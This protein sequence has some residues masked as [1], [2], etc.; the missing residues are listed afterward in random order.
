MSP[1]VFTA[2]SSFSKAICDDQGQFGERSKQKRSLSG[3]SGL[4]RFPHLEAAPGCPWLSWKGEQAA[5][6]PVPGEAA[7]AALWGWTYY[8]RAKE[9]QRE[10]SQPGQPT[11]QGLC[12]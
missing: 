6:D 2:S 11:G 5:L 8:R 1:L 4:L 12:R 9:E 7:R 10:E 3:L